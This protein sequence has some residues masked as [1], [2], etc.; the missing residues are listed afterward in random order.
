M[1]TEPRMHVN[2]IGIGIKS[3][4]WNEFDA[5]RILERGRGDNKFE[6]ARRRSSVE[7]AQTSDS[8]LDSHEQ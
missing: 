4:F 8:R 6:N 7:P 5:Y 3:V 2:A 1:E